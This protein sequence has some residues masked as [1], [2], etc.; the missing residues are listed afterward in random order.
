MMNELLAP[1]LPLPLSLPL[2]VSLALELWVWVWVW[3]WVWSMSIHLPHLLFWKKKPLD[4]SR[5]KKKVKHI[6]YSNYPLTPRQR[7]HTHTH[8]PLQELGAR[9]QG[10]SFVLYT[11]VICHSQSSENELFCFLF[12]AEKQL[13]KSKAVA[14]GF[15]APGLYEV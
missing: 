7:A 15:W 11:G 3:V 4:F 1:L 6:Q 2:S 5:S 14:N 10:T 9:G 8:T 13:Q 12:S